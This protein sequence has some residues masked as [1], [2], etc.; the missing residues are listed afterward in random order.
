VCFLDQNPLSLGLLTRLV[1]RRGFQVVS[2][3]EI[4]EGKHL[5]TQETLVLVIDEKL[6]SPH[7]RLFLEA[8][9]MRYPKAKFLV[10]DREHLQVEEDERLD[11]I[12]GFVLYAEVRN[13]LIPALRTLCHGHLWL[14]RAVLERLSQLAGRGTES[15]KAPSLTPREAQIFT[16][17]QQELSNKE[18]GNELRIS[19]RTV[20]FHLVNIFNKLAVHNRYAAAD[21]AA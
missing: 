3:K 9:R 7:D 13:M 12:H 8:L 19:E 6:L 5:P 10:L 17:L 21:G 2:E 18:I 1:Q 14:P 11:G 15:K 4:R 20:K 16:L